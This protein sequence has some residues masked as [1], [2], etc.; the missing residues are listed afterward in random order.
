MRAHTHQ[1]FHRVSSGLVGVLWC[2]E[3]STTERSSYLGEAKCAPLLSALYL[4]RRSQSRKRNGLLETEELVAKIPAAHVLLSETSFAWMGQCC[5]DVWARHDGRH[6]AE[7]SISHPLHTWVLLVAPLAPREPIRAEGS[8]P[9]SGQKS[10]IVYGPSA[11]RLVLRA[12]SLARLEPLG[13]ML[14]SVL[15]CRH[16][17]SVSGP[18]IST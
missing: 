7:H 12:V 9:C 3:R 14:R 6:G 10:V 4:R 16:L 1:G 15:A 13:K 5:E 18:L 2:H 8:T 11:Y 17:P